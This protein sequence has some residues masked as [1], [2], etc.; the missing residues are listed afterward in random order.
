MY[1]MLLFAGQP[2]TACVRRISILSFRAELPL[3]L[4]SSL[5][6]LPYSTTTVLNVLYITDYA[7]LIRSHP[8]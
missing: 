5:L 7:A 6:V 1:H 2:Q 3:S 8:I 4:F